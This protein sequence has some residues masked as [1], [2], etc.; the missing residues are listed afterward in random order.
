MECPIT[1]NIEKH[2]FAFPPNITQEQ[3]YIY[4]SWLTD[5]SFIT[6]P[7]NKRLHDQNQKLHKQLLSYKDLINEYYISKCWD[8]YKKLSNNYELVSTDSNGTHHISKLSTISRSFYKLWEILHDLK[9]EIALPIQ[10]SLCCAFLAEGPGGFIEAFAKY[11]SKERRQLHNAPIKD[12]MYGMT[13]ISANRSVPNWKLSKSFI[14]ENN[15]VLLQGKDSTGSLYN[16]ENIIDLVDTIGKNSCN[17]VTADGGF[18]FSNDFNVQEQVSIQ[19]VASEILAAIMLQKPGG[20]CVI[21]VFDICNPATLSL[22]SM[23]HASYNKVFVTKPH[24]SRPANSEKYIICTGYTNDVV[25]HTTITT[26]LKD[27]VISQNIPSLATIFPCPKLICENVIEMNKMF[28][29]RQLTNIVKTINLIEANQHNPSSPTSNEQHMQ[30]IEKNVTRIQLEYA[31]R[32][33]HKYN[34]PI[35]MTAVKTYKSKYYS[36]S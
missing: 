8:K 18:D 11:V 30:N 21:K 27:V 10:D 22:I 28:I 19:L 16:V 20:T 29:L 12:K 3:Q 17:I 7:T 5:T 26:T 24:T 23:L 31:I 15:L 14:Q 2:I 36:S 35:S 9:D 32:W 34:I 13:L 25:L 4:T 6:P 1:I 33:C